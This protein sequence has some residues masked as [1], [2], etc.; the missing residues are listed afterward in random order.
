[1]GKLTI[2]LSDATEERLRRHVSKTYPVHSFGKLGE[3]IEKAIVAYLAV[4]YRSDDDLKY[5]L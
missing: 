3:V 2:N 1:M 4:D 5:D